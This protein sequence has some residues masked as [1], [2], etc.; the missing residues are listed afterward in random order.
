MIVNAVAPVF[1]H[2]VLKDTELIWER[3]LI[4]IVSC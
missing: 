3:R 1:M 2:Q 4:Y